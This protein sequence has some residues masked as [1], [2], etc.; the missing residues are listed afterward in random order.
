ME[1]INI[2]LVAVVASIITV[3]GG[4]IAAILKNENLRTAVSNRLI[5]GIKGKQIISIDDLKRHDIL[6]KVKR[7]LA[8]GNHRAEDIIDDTKRI[9][10]FR[11]Y[12]N[13]LCEVFV[14]SV[15][16][17]LN[18]DFINF[19]ESDL[20]S[21]IVEQMAWRREQYNTR[22]QKYLATLHNDNAKI[23]VILDKIE[24]WRTIECEIINNSVLDI[25]SSGRFKSVEY[26]LDVVLHQ[27]ALGIDVLAKNGADSFIKLNGE[28]DDF[29]NTK[30]NG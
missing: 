24:R 1:E 14:E 22:L 11:E 25:I 12:V 28:L 19:G 23:V 13:T 9:V 10:V 18:T 29:L 15:E 7:I 30:N 16:N 8:T 2:A 21:L 3:V 20:K 17:I 27:Y 26:K 6:L 4:F 5:G